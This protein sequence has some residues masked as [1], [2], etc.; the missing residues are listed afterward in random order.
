[1]I[2]SHPSRIYLGYT[3]PGYTWATPLPDIPGLHPSRIYLGYIFATLSILPCVIIGTVQRHVLGTLGSQTLQQVP[4][5][6]MVQ[7]YKQSSRKIMVSLGVSYQDLRFLA[8]RF[9]DWWWSNEDDVVN[10]T[11]PDQGDHL[12]E[13]L[14]VFCNGYMLARRMPTGQRQG[15]RHNLNQNDSG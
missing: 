11:L 2:V 5:H 6:K 9:I 10:S 12:L 7:R 1:M 14:L 3:P 15:Q 13:I 8:G 4:N